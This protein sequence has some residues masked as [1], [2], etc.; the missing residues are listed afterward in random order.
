MIGDTLFGLDV[1]I[2]LLHICDNFF[3]FPGVSI[4]LKLL[5]Q[6]FGKTVSPKV[7]EGWENHLFLW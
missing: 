2:D 5:N 1:A 6:R 4:T 3:T 7:H